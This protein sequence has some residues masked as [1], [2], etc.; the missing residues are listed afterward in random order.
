MVGAFA[1]IGGAGGRV[2]GRW[3][4]VGRRLGLGGSRAPRALWDAVGRNAFVASGGPLRGH[5]VQRGGE[6]VTRG[7]LSRE[8]LGVS[9]SA[10]RPGEVRRA[11]IH[12]SNRSALNVRASFFMSCFQTSQNKVLKS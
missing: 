4:F 6:A 8:V 11:R 3:A 10:A 9:G 2:P 7:H 12:R 5:F 1:R